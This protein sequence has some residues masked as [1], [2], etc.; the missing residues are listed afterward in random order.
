MA[1]GTE[2]A[3]PV[4]VLLIYDSLAKGSALEGNVA[5]VQRLLAVYGARVTIT[6]MDRYAKGAVTA[7]GKVI[8][9]INEGKSEARAASGESPALQADLA[10]FS[11]DLLQVDPFE[12]KNSKAVLGIA[13]ELKR[14]LGISTAGRSYLLLK[15]VYPFSDL[16]LLRLTADQ[17]YDAGI[18]FLVSAVPVF[19]NTDYP[20]MKR[21]VQALRYVQS[22]GGSIA[23]NAPVVQLAIGKG[24]RTLQAKMK[25]FLE[26]LVDGGVAPLTIAAENYWTYDREY[27]N[28]GLGFFDSAVLFPD[29]ETP[30]MEQTFTSKPFRMALFALPPVF[31]EQSGAPTGN[32]WNPP[33]DTAITYTFWTKQADMEQALEQL[34]QYWIRFADFR[35]D[36][37]LVQTDRYK[38]VSSGGRISLNGT[39]L[40]VDDLGAEISG[41]FTY[42]EEQ[43]QSFTGFF[44]AQNLFFLIVI[45]LS[46]TVFGG[47]MLIGRRLYRRKYFK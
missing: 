42:V 6:S 47:F 32:S 20:A 37:H 34:R 1:A 45:A 16:E 44:H 23:V 33:M 41:N 40:N 17:L 22:R 25:V 27:A 12:S 43:Q 14:W 28:A 11:G 31:L 2:A 24:D 46:L 35:Q 8:V 15:E 38:I 30:Y 7:F 5:V 3:E 36:T 10:G 13:Q 19:V 26:A 9:M 18:P 21:Y 4:G 29:T 39:S